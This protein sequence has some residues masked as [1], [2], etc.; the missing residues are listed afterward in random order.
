MALATDTVKRTELALRRVG[1]D[2]RR[3]A[4]T[5]LPL[6]PEPDERDDV[7]CATQTLSQGDNS[8]GV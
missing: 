2:R 6:A 3:V 4:T 8:P 5:G 7:A 1:A